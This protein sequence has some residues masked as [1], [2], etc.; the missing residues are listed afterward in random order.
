M[1]FV[2]DRKLWLRGEGDDRSL[3]LRDRDGKMCCLGFY[4]LALGF[5]KEDIREYACPSEVDGEVNY[6]E[7][8]YRDDDLCDTMSS[9]TLS[10]MTINDSKFLDDESR[11]RRITEIFASSSVEVEFVG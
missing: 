2:I 6:P 7:W 1:K 10:L 9:K 3:L 5:D 8:M 4:S 11:E